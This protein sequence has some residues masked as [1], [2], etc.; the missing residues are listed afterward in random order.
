MSTDYSDIASKA[1][2]D[3]CEDLKQAGEVLLRQ[4][5][6]KDQ[7]TQSEGLRY[8]IRQVHVGFE[9]A[10]ELQDMQHP[11][12]FPMVGSHKL[13]EG[14]TGDCRFHHAYFDGRVTNILRG[15]RGQSPLIEIGV[16]NGKGG[17]SENSVQTAGITEE[18]L[19]VNADG[20]FELVLSPRKPESQNDGSNWIETSADS[21]YIMI[22]E[23]AANWMGLQPGQYEMRREGAGYA[24]GPLKMEPLL[25]GIEG[26]KHW[27]QSVPK[28]WAAISDFWLNLAP[29][30]FVEEIP[31]NDVINIGIP[32]GHQFAVCCMTLEP[33][34]AMIVRFKPD[35]V[36]YWSLS[37]VNYW[38]EPLAYREHFDARQT[39]TAIN[40]ATATIEADGSVK[41]IVANRPSQG[42]NWLDTR[43]HE[44]CTVLF[45]ISRSPNPVPKFETEFVDLATLR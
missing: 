24:Q 35:D 1:W 41:A 30:K 23:Y 8:L 3:F 34:Q 39:T 18:Q 6:P 17:F 45:R 25:E 14:V 37:L 9:N 20:S 2:E 15:K 38:W 27:M 40:N 7:I 36:P 11:R 10:Y 43:G 31:Q 12:M 13:Y 21:S 5:T 29:N 4:N 26:T 16:Y 42:P 28:R 33:G 32:K 44:R 22:R 19:K